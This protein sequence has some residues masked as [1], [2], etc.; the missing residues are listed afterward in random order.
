M[1]PFWMGLKHGIF[2]WKNRDKHGKDLDICWTSFMN[3]FLCET[4]VSR[5]REMWR[6]SVVSNTLHLNKNNESIG[7]NHFALACNLALEPNLVSAAFSEKFIKKTLK[8]V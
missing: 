1:S 5:K 3:G 8:H 6:K 7:R 2:V 4:L